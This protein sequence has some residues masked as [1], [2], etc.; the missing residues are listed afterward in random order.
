MIGKILGYAITF[1]GIKISSKHFLGIGGDLYMRTG[2]VTFQTLVSKITACEAILSNRGFLVSHAP[3]ARDILWNNVSVPRKTIMWRNMVFNIA[4]CV[5]GLFWSSMVGLIINFR[6]YLWE[7]LGS[8]STRV[9]LYIRGIFYNYFVT[10]ILLSIIQLLPL[11]FRLISRKLIW[12][13]SVSEVERR[14][15]SRFFS[16]QV[17]MIRLTS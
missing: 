5:F 4:L 15:V 10:V 12:E 14:L 13:K 3:E 1:V 17:I 6:D 11:L 8:G 2:F 7:S 16:F 9:Y